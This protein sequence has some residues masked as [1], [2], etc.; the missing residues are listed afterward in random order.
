MLLIGFLAEKFYELQ[1]FYLMTVFCTHCS[2]SV[3][4]CL[5]IQSATENILLL[6][7]SKFLFL[8]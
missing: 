8:L 3:I 2:T 7:Q 4:S 5:N 1:Q 6:L